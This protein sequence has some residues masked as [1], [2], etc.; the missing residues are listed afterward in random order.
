M[1]MR[2][3]GDKSGRA[4]N[5]ARVSPPA[6]LFVLPNLA[7]GGA[8]RVTLTLLD[9]LDRSRF[10]P[11]LAVFETAGPLHASLRSDVPLH[12]LKRPRLSRALPALLR[13][14]RRRR[15]AVV[16]ATHGYVSLALLA[17]RPVL[18]K[19]TRIVVRESNTPSQSLPSG[20]FPWA[21]RFAYRRLYPRAEA[22]LCQHRKTEEEMRD[23]FGVAPERVKSLPNPVDSIA[24][25]AAAEPVSREPGD[26]PRFV[27][28]GRLTRQKGFDRLLDMMVELADETHLTICGSGPEQAALQARAADLGLSE[29]VRFAGFRQPLAPLLAGADACL[30][31]SRWEGL[32]NVALEALACGTAVIASPESGGIAEL[33]GAVTIAEIGPPFVEAMKAVV[34]GDADGLPASRLPARYDLAETLSRF[35]AIVEHVCRT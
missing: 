14:I 18:P 32:P 6:V 7:G 4:S 15:P 20:A 28:A 33:A 10:A 17:A 2:P 23:H 30:V 24:L 19:D 11:E 21:T 16:F 9:N 12:D 35:M 1:R 5:F 27:A 31:P 25:R 22:I 13:L 8:E 34:P 29:R 26:G 3:A